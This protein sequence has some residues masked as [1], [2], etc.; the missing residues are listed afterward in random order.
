M[1]RKYGVLNN[2]SNDDALDQQIDTDTYP[3]FCEN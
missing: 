1:V 3:V 2:E